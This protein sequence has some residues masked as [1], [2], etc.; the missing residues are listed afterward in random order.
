MIMSALGAAIVTLALLVV[1][2]RMKEDCERGAIRAM[3]AGRATLDAT[4]DGSL[5]HYRTAGQILEEET[6]LKE[7][8]LRSSR[9]LAFTYAD[10]A[11]DRAS[12][13]LVAVLDGAGRVLSEAR[14]H[15]GAGN[16]APVPL[17]VLASG[18][19]AAGFAS[20][21]GRFFMIVVVPV[22][23]GDRTLGHLLLGDPVTRE[24][25]AHAAHGS[26]VEITLLDDLHQAKIASGTEEEAR[27]I[28]DASGACTGEVEPITIQGAPFLRM[29]RPLVGI[30]G[31]PLGC[32]VITRPLGAELAELRKMQLWL[33]GLGALVTLLAVAGGALTAYRIATPL[34]RLTRSAARIA[35]GDLASSIEADASG[36]VGMLER[37]VCAMRARLLLMIDEAREGAAGV[38]EAAERVAR[39]SRRVADRATAQAASAQE[40]A[41]SLEEMSASIT[42][43]ADH[44]RRMAARAEADVARAEETRRAMHATR[45]AMG[46]IADRVTAVEEIA[47]QTNLLS[48]NATIE[49]AHAGGRGKGFAVVAEEVR[50]LAERSRGAAH[51]ILAL[52]RGS[53]DAA[54][55][56]SGMAEAVLASSRETADVARAVASAMDQQAVGVSQVNVAMVQVGRITQENIVSAEELARTARDLEARAASLR[57]HTEEVR[58]ERG[59]AS[60]EPESGERRLVGVAAES[61][62]PAPPTSVARARRS[63]EAA[64]VRRRGRG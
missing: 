46:A 21:E 6:L 55:R 16:A 35:E 32:T 59:D 8:L 38:V 44:G 52:A 42:H 48:L 28:A 49:A 58:V 20:I 18:R 40:T 19:G 62:S 39:T 15:F 24:A 47:Y 23:L 2:A 17:S 63:S 11:H 27:A 36:E 56:S 61:P 26:E 45:D 50:R 10:S 25:L 1:H 43:T 7:A 51:E 22:R 34:H 53:V 60:S 9:E 13:E 12:F 33:V 57:V 41:A 37:A 29:A 64:T 4:L 14:P 54:V 31:G 5:E 30:G 3:A